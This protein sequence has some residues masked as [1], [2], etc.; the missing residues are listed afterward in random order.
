[1]ICESALMTWHSKTLY[2]VQMLKA[3][4]STGT[5]LDGHSPDGWSVQAGQDRARYIME[6]LPM[7]ARHSRRADYSAALPPPPNPRLSKA[8]RKQKAAAVKK[9]AC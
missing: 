7:G 6:Q 9:C 3:G 8:G 1:M 2:V 4:L 5:R